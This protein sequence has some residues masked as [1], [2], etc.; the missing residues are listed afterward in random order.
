MTKKENSKLCKS[1]NIFRKEANRERLENQEEQLDFLQSNIKEINQFHV[2][3]LA[4][5]LYNKMAINQ[6]KR[7]RA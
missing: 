2:T 7:E 1:L 4:D 3:N 6:Y 5:K